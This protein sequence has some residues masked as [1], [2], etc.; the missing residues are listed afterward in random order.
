MRPGVCV[1]RGKRARSAGVFAA[2]AALFACSSSAST[3]AQGVVSTTLRGRAFFEGPLAERQVVVVDH[4]SDGPREILAEGRTDR[5]GRFAVEIGPLFGAFLVEVS[6][7][8]RTD[9]ERLSAPV[10]VAEAGQ[11]YGDIQVTPITEFVTTYAAFLMKEGR[12]F[13]E[14]LDRARTLLHEHFGGMDHARVEAI[15][16]RAGPVVDASDG[17]VVG[18][19]LAGFSEEARLFRAQKTQ[20]SGAQASALALVRAYAR[21][22]EDGVFDGRARFGAELSFAGVPIDVES[23][24]LRYANAVESFL[25]STANATGLK[26]EGFASVLERIRTN[27]SVLFPPGSAAARDRD[28]PEMVSVVLVDERGRERPDGVPVRGRVQLRVRAEDPSGVETIRA[29]G[30]GLGEAIGD[31]AAPEPEDGWFRIDT[32]RLLDGPYAVE[33]VFS[34]VVGN[35]RRQTI[36]LVAD[37]TAPAVTLEGRSRTGTATVG[38]SGTWTDAIGPVDIEVFV[39]GELGARLP[40]PA[41]PF[42]ATVAVPCSGLPVMITAVAMDAAGNRSLPAMATTLCDAEGPQIILQP[43]SFI[44]E[45]D[46][47]L[48]K[49]AAGT[50]VYTVPPGARRLTISESTAFPVVLEKY[51]TR[52]DDLPQRGGAAGANLPVLSLRF[53]DENGPILAARY[54]YLVG[55]AAVR[56][57]TPL[58]VDSSGGA[59]IPISYQALSPELIR[60]DASVLHRIEIEA[61]DEVGNSKARAFEFRI[62]VLSPPV[63]FEACEP[64]GDLT[65]GALPAAYT[66]S[67]E[68]PA[69]R[70]DLLYALDLPTGSLAPAGGV[71]LSITL[72]AASSRILRLSEQKFSA[73]SFT[74]TYNGSCGSISLLELHE[75]TDDWTGIQRCSIPGFLPEERVFWDIQTHGPVNDPSTHQ[76]A[77]SLREIAGAELSLVGGRHPL[78]ADQATMLT[79]RLV[80]PRL[81]RNGVSYNF[82]TAYPAVPSGFSAS[83]NVGGKYRLADLSHSGR[84]VKVV[85]AGVLARAFVTRASIDRFEVRTETVNI[86]AVHPMLP[87][88]AIEVRQ[89]ASCNQA[90]IQELSE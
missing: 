20:A 85:Y 59:T 82:S 66:T 57:W 14:A 36:S 23:V 52:L 90:V 49:N 29:S 54:R 48:S 76:T 19:L 10:E 56:A 46:L 37:N 8:E 27:E 35:E 13:S 77:I 84:D 47:V 81:L 58:V 45:R 65:W 6:A 15:D 34:D 5:D 53:F 83:V 1:S 75:I 9:G 44:Q 22:L 26:A 38:V 79:V 88:V 4:E 2:S 55:G 41:S 28:G 3:D 74:T 72:P 42:S 67:L 62:D 32:T 51:F 50:L 21:D 73:A 12:G 80:S 89:D 64:T 24:R 16:P 31:D 60:R 40:R 17:V 87:H 30:E 43:T 7:V 68:V 78:S 86:A 71:N 61:V 25:G 63:W 33:L 70:G 39:A 69:V 18:V 11:V